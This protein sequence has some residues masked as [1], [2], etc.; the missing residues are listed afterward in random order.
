ML[1][2]IT[3]VRLR[4]IKR[5][6]FAIKEKEVKGNF[7]LQ[8]KL[9]IDFKKLKIFLMKNFQQYSKGLLVHLK[10]KQYKYYVKY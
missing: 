6:R 5:E 8:K 7:V 4:N 10:Q 3:K 2:S 1:S 9:K